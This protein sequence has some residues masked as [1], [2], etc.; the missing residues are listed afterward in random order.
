MEKTKDKDE[1]HP[2]EASYA[3]NKNADVDYREWPRWLYHRNGQSRVFASAADIPADERD[4]WKN[5][6]LEWGSANTGQG[7]RGRHLS[8]SGDIRLR[9]PGFDVAD[10]NA[11][12]DPV[13][14]GIAE[15]D[16]NAQTVYMRPPPMRDPQREE[17]AAQKLPKASDAAESAERKPGQPARTADAGHEP[18]LKPAKG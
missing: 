17:A 7:L 10:M 5:D 18:A 15:P 13:R 8:G 1:L 3:F 16:P 4:D 11:T 14:S 2:V 12:Q 6:P 9:Y